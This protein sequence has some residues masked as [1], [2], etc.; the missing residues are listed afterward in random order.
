M[1]GGGQAEKAQVD[2]S[3]AQ[4]SEDILIAA[5]EEL[6]GDVWMLLGKAVQQLGENVDRYA[7]KGAD[8]HLAH[9]QPV[10]AGGLAQDLLVLLTHR[11][12]G[13]GQGLPLGGQAHA[14]PIPDQ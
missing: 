6:K 1:V 10:E 14:E 7:E 2:A 13:G 4:P 9:L 11:P 5:L 3:L 12:D 8:A